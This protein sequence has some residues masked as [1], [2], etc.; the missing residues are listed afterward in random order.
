MFG[1]DGHKELAIEKKRIS[2]RAGDR[3]GGGRETLKL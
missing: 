2:H 1:R 3:G